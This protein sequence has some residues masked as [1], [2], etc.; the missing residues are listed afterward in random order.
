MNPLNTV[1]GTIVGGFVLAIAIA[2]GIAA[3]TG[4]KLDTV[5]RAGRAIECS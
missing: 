4:K 2:A 3:G 1:M 5:I